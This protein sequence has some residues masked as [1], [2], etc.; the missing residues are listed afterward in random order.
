MFP[1]SKR[2][3]LR[4]KLVREIL[5]ADAD[6]LDPPPRL[7]EP[8]RGKQRRRQQQA[9]ALLKRLPAADLETLWAAVSSK[10]ASETS[11]AAACVRVPTT[12]RLQPS[13]TAAA[14]GGFVDPAALSCSLFRWPRLVAEEEEL[15]RMPFCR[16]EE[17]D[18][19]CCNPFHWSRMT[20]LDPGRIERFGSFMKALICRLAFP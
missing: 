15:L 16:G 18:W 10:G 11:T 17:G 7:P 12:L 13:T 1:C 2:R 4:D 19:K 6:Q 8:E 5:D 14:A 20:Q 3:S 9:R